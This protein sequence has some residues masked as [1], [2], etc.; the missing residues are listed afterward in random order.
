MIKD[1]LKAMLV[2]HAS[3]AWSSNNFVSTDDIDGAISFLVDRKLIIPVGEFYYGQRYYILNRYKMK[4][5]K[6]LVNL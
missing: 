3:I 5:I 6:L 4:E 2:N 1:I